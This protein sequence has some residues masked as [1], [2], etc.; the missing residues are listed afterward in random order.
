MDF[1]KDVAVFVAPILVFMLAFF[2]AA[3]AADYYRNAQSVDS[4]DRSAVSDK[5]WHRTVPTPDG[6][7]LCV[8][9]RDSIDCNWN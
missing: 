9:Y 1:L 3:V 6:D 7:V 2:G 5:A 8:T 4:A